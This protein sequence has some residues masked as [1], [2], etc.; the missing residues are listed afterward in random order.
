MMTPKRLRPR[1]PSSSPSASPSS[2]PSASPSASPSPTVVLATAVPPTAHAGDTV[3]M[4]APVRRERL[5][6]SNVREHAHCAA[7][8]LS[9][10]PRVPSQTTSRFARSAEI[11]S[12]HI[13][14]SGVGAT[15]GTRTYRFAVSIT[16]EDSSTPSEGD[17][18]PVAGQINPATT[19]PLVSN[20]SVL[21]RTG[22][23]TL[24]LVEVAMFLLIVGA[25]TTAI[26][27]RRGA[28]PFQTELNMHRP[29]RST[30]DR[31]ASKS[32]DWRIRSAANAA[33]GER[34]LPGVTANAR[35]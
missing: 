17:D 28:R 9:R 27:R 18:S 15:G 31:L 23:D 12:H 7:Q 19:V 13:V 8:T 1:S 33:S 35:N 29:P 14:V 34:A 25:V 21:P 3:H 22:S 5:F 32:K 26:S 11:G 10:A 24:R 30:A 2:S 4:R 6:A 20:P 16:P